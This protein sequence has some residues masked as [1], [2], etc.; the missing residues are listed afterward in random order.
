MARVKMLRKLT[1]D[2]ER[3]LRAAVADAC[4]DAPKATAA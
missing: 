4:A 3:D 2:A 1:Q